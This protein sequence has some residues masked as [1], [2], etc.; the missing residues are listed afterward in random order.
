[1][2]LAEPMTADPEIPRD[3]FVQALRY[4]LR[5]SRYHVGFEPEGEASAF[6]SQKEAVVGAVEKVSA[7]L[8]GAFLPMA[9]TGGG[10]AE[11]A[12]AALVPFLAHCDLLAYRV[13]LGAPTV[14]PVTFA[15]GVPA[16]TVRARLTLY[17]ELGQ[18]LVDFG[19]G[20][21]GEGMGATV[22]PLVFYFEPDGY[23]TPEGAAAVLSSGYHT[24]TPKDAALDVDRVTMIATAVHVP[25]RRVQQ[26]QRATPPPA[27]ARFLGSA[28]KR[29]MAAFNLRTE[30]FTP[31]DLT[32]VVTLAQHFART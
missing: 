26:A 6:E 19:L 11:A 12:L 21:N 15:D 13:H 23:D 27:V 2:T 25:T 14:V 20:F 32:T 1:M 30:T 24:P 9:I 10:S 17:R 18:G 7:A 5:S 29:A 16:E 3:A 4:W 8:G 28:I 22:A 31:A